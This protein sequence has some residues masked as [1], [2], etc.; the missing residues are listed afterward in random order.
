M[1]GR[2][3]AVATSLQFR[4]SLWLGFTLLGAAGV[5]GSVS[6]YAA[7]GEAIEFQDDV[8]RHISTLY[9]QPNQPAPRIVSPDPSGNRDVE[10]RV[11]VQLLGPTTAD[12]AGPPPRLSVALSM[13]LHSGMQTVH[14]GEASYRVF[15]R[16]LGTGQRLAVAQGTSARDE[17]ARDSALRTLTPLLVLFPV[18]FA[19]VIYLIRRSFRPVSDLAREL[20][21]RGENEFHA[22]P[23][24]TVP[25][26]VRP[27]VAA[28]NRL[29]G[30]IGK[31]LE[32]QRRFVADAA[33]ELRSPLTAL[34]LQAERLASA[35]MSHDATE[36]LATL[37]L[38]IDRGRVLVS[39]LL[40]LARAE[41]AVAAPGS[42]VS[43]QRVY[44]HALERLLSLAEAKG[45][46]VG[47]TSTQ[48][49]EVQ[50][51]EADLDAL[52]RNLVENAIRYTPK[53]G[54]V[55]LSVSTT[56]DGVTLVVEDTGPGIPES[57]RERVF[58]RFYRSVGSDEIG[59]GL[60]L[61]IVK[62]ISRR[63]GARV[64]L[65]SC[66][67]PDRSGL[68]VTVTFQTREPGGRAARP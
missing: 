64:S 45:V 56:P 65:G 42:A 44:R 41:S 7:F 52:V 19:V 43:V 46:D 61:S 12:S 58:E 32:D 27:F 3:G 17:I 68:R 59:S 67:D 38:G 4:L 25:S 55:D 54:R 10:S 6:Y 30:R 9:E 18:M 35:E 63:I 39:Q 60:G 23:V 11:F 34:S 66:D 36:R 28:I 20:D 8:L 33:H 48:D 14:S 24:Q 16:T 26:E 2:T 47:I 13:D 49:V 40:A 31:S 15:V 21:L 1:D 5:A 62:A 50:T 51:S 57:E 29:L 37:R 53:G 22:M